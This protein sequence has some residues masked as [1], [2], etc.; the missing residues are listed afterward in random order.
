M[1]AE[2]IRPLADQEADGAG[3][4][5][6]VNNI[7]MGDP[8][9]TYGSCP[10]RLSPA[11][12]AL[13]EE[14]A[15]PVRV[16]LDAGL[17]TART[18]QELPADAHWIVDKGVGGADALPALVRPLK[19]PVSGDAFQ[20]H[21]AVPVVG[22]DA[23]SPAKYVSPSRRAGTLRFGIVRDVEGPVT[24]VVEGFFQSLAA[25][26]WAPAD[27]SIFLI[28]GIQSWMVR[29][30]V[31][32]EPSRPAPDL[33]VLGGRDVVIVPDADVASNPR[34]FRGATALGRACGDFGASSVRFVRVPGAGK[35]GLDDVLAR[36]P[37][38]ERTE[39]L[40]AA[41]SGAVDTPAD[42]PAGSGGVADGGSLPLVDIVQPTRVVEAAVVEALKARTG[43]RQVFRVGDELACLSMRRDGGLE[44]RRLDA[45]GLLHE[46]SQTVD[47]ARV[48]AKGVPVHCALPPALLSVIPE[49]ARG[50]LPELAGV[51]T[52][53]MILAD[54]T[55]LT[56][57]GYDERS[58]MY[59]APSREMVGLDVPEHPTDD[60]LVAARSL[61]RDELLAMDGAGGYDSWIFKD[62]ADQT[63][64]AAALLTL[65]VRPHLGK[66]PLMLCSALTPGSGKGYLIDVL[67]RVAFGSPAAFMV[68]T[69]NAD[70]TEK[71]VAAEL[72]R[73][74]SSIV[75]DE[76][77]PA[78]GARS[79][80]EHGSRLGH[81]AVLSGTTAEW[82]RGRILGR[83]ETVE[84]RNVATWFA[85]GNNVET[86]EDVASR[87][88]AI[89]FASDRDDI[90]TR[91]NWRHRGADWATENR[92]ALVR[93][94]LVILRAWYARGR[95]AAPR[96]L[97]LGR[98]EEWQDVIGGAL[99]LAGFEDFLG[100]VMEVRASAD[101]AL[102][103]RT[104]FLEWVAKHFAPGTRFTASD[105]IGENA[106]N[107]IAPAPYDLS[108]K[109]LD[110]RDLSRYL[111]NS[112][113]W[114]GDMRVAEAGKVH[115]VRAF[116]LEE[117]VSVLGGSGAAAPAAPAAPVAPPAPTP[118]VFALP[119]DE[120]DAP[121]L[122]T[123]SELG[124]GA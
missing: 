27:W 69:S 42:R 72:L 6:T 64:A 106:R 30:G 81:S 34:V 44:A 95:P 20:V 123:V 43:R 45:S 40:E 68:M 60:D 10:P 92:P 47:V 77:Q 120:D 73:G 38:G 19:Q 63:H 114:A 49:A 67:H 18:E 76:V 93:A 37:E 14:H 3:G 122:P 56:Q 91:G 99:H 48:S 103:E 54:G 90:T 115:N 98:Y 78:E 107:P 31:D 66:A 84:L 41:V 2:R 5:D 80:G 15:V 100:N 61:I 59:L 97:S 23:D 16:A 22:L 79:H 71:R 51:T 13:C 33:A 74:A 4:L 57:P 70:E 52:A 28:A 113:S 117:K 24:L 121:A 8:S 110:S 39:W 86:P 118:S 9:A 85:T 65:F 1:S 108:W 111:K 32:G 94:A 87:V 35:D 50:E 58:G 7:S 26:S 105:L 29:S 96:T 55:V 112:G 11:H 12:E 21:P 124:G 88:L 109:T 25:L 62:V 101:N 75:L 83:T 119:T 46:I 102:I 53:P 89:R 17:Y 116:T 82:Y 36:M 104:E